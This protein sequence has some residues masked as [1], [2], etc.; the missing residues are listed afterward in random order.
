[1]K[2]VIYAKYEGMS[3]FCAFSLG[4]GCCVDRLIYASTCNAFEAKSVCAMLQNIADDNK[5]L[6]LVF[7][8]R[9]NGTNKVMFQTA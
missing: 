1:M 7:Q 8:L 2:Y 3:R 9:E 4:D 6:N 5:V